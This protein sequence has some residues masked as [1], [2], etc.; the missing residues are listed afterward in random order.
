VREVE[1]TVGCLEVREKE[2]LQIVLAYG[3]PPWRE[4]APF[5]FA[6]K[7]PLN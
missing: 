5:T 6:P 3:L 2:K 4:H 1:E 7:D